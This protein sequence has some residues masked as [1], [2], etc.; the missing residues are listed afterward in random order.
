[1]LLTALLLLLLCASKMLIGVVM[2]ITFIG[3]HR[4]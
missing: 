3:G 4:F 2:Y 1:L